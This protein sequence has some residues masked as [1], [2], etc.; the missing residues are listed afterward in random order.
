MKTRKT[1]FLENKKINFILENILSNKNYED[2]S[3]LEQENQ[4]GE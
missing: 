4:I 2:K 1:L 3:V